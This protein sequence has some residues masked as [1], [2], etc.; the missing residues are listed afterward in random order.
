MAFMSALDFNTDY[1][2][3]NLISDLRQ[4]I[5]LCI[6]SKI[7]GDINERHQSWKCRQICFL[8]NKRS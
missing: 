4:V 5:V 8:G 6:A 7:M 3:N 1:L 2:V